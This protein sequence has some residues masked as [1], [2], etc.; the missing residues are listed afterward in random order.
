MRSVAAAA[1]K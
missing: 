1:M